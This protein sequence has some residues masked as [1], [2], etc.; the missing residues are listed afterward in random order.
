MNDKALARLVADR[1]RHQPEHAGLSLDELGWI[2]WSDLVGALYEEVDRDLNADELSHILETNNYGRFDI[3]EDGVRA[4]HG[5][6]T[7]QVT[8]PPQEPPETLYDTVNGRHLDVIMDRGLI[9]D[10]GYRQVHDD[11]DNAVDARSNLNRKTLIEIDANEAWY[12]GNVFYQFN[13]AWYIEDVE[14]SY[15]TSI[16]LDEE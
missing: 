8:Y 4:A 1:L 12:N 5:H 9:P 10:R 15:L 16:P 3:R 7:P 13:D 14:S 11:R 6:T 2:S